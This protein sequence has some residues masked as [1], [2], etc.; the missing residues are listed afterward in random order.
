MH[1]SE[2]MVVGEKE[3][4]AEAL[5]YLADLEVFGDSDSESDIEINHQDCT[6]IFIQL[7]VDAIGNISDID[8]P[9]EEELSVNNLSGNQ[10]LASAIL[11]LKEVGKG[12]KV[13]VEHLSNV[14]PSVEN[15]T[16]SDVLASS[17]TRIKKRKLDLQ[18]KTDKCDAAK[19]KQPLRKKV[20][21]VHGNSWQ[22][23][24]IQNS[25]E[26]NK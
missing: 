6:R 22:H 23:K 9:D 20:K 10:L 2:K 5:M 14:N 1:Y 7:P 17:S 8:S 3:N 25:N 24:D 4:L 16:V 19:K 12:A 15:Q 21:Q 26:L 11:Y 13:S 18:N